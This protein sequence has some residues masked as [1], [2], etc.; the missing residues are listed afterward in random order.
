MQYDNCLFNDCPF[1]VIKLRFTWLDVAT[2]GELLLS[3]FGNSTNT[4]S[5]YSESKMFG[6]DWWE[7]F[8]WIDIVGTTSIPSVSSVS[9]LN[10]VRCLNCAFN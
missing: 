2:L 9:V 4:I 7:G 3:L 1:N 10:S 5:V 6:C 8:A